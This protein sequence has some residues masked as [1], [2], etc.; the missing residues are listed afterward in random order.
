MDF[1][2]NKVRAVM[3]HIAGY[4]HYLTSGKVKPS[5]ITAL[6]LIGHI[7][8][9]WALVNC[10][11]VLAAILLA[12]FSLL[13]AL[14]GSLARIQKSASL[15]GMLFDAVSDRAKEIIVFSALGVY[16]YKHIGDHL[17]WVVIAATGTSLL[18]SYVKAKGEMAVASTGKTN[19]Q[20]LNRLFSGGLASYEVR[21]A[22]LVTGLLFGF[23][24]LALVVILIANV[25]TVSTRFL[26]ISKAL[27]E[28]DSKPNKKK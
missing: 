5:H 9:A 4:V 14:D 25:V 1:I 3:T 11:P 24:E 18:V 2:R 7:P 23:V 21:T 19:A 17:I 16:A 15:S 13:D 10:R 12:G 27:H 28:L 6:S 26:R 8:V 22:A 20:K